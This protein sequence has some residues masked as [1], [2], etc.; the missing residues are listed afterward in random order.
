MSTD[1]HQS[2]IDH[3][4]NVKMSTNND[5]RSY[6]SFG[7]VITPPSPPSSSPP[8]SSSSVSLL[9]EKFPSSSV[10]NDRV[11]LNDRKVIHVISR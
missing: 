4:D 7:L 11:Q 2:V 8:P 6:I 5:S 3:N 10:Q 9:T 1:N